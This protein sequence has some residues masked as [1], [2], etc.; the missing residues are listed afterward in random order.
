[1]AAVARGA[2]AG[3]G[4]AFGKRALWLALETHTSSGFN[5]QKLTK[6]LFNSSVGPLVYPK[7]VMGSEAIDNGSKEDGIAGQDGV[8]CVAKSSAPLLDIIRP[9]QSVSQRGT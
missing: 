8:G 2:R 6:T 5:E 7:T 4:S 3:R 1:M 9:C